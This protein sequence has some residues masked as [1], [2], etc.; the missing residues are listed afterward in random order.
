ME[1]KFSDAKLFGSGFSI[2]IGCRV[3]NLFKLNLIPPCKQCLYSTVH[4]ILL[5]RLYMMEAGSLNLTSWRMDVWATWPD[6]PCSETFKPSHQRGQA[7]WVQWRMSPTCEIRE[8][9]KC[10]ESFARILVTTSS[11]CDDYL[12]TDLIAWPRPT[13][14]QTSR[15]SLGGTSCQIPK[16]SQ[17]SV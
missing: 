3:A 16:T 14:L 6:C 8:Y 7:M 5:D 9:A 1:F 2:A 4:I 17:S 15:F 10:W 11:S 13:F 12:Q